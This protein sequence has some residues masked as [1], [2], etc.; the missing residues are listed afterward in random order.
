MFHYIIKA[1]VKAWP[2]RR[3]IVDTFRTVRNIEQKRE[4]VREKF[5]NNLTF[6]NF[7]SRSVLQITFYPYLLLKD[8]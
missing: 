6:I 8:A 1:L 2:F 3:Y 4:R 7:S 5:E